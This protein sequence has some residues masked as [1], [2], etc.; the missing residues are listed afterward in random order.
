[1]VSDTYIGVICSY[2]NNDWFSNLDNFKG[3]DCYRCR[4]ML[5][6]SRSV[7]RGICKYNAG[8]TVDNYY[9]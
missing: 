4:F 9:Y 3:I 1:M 5:Y 6:S 7:R 2:T 8:T